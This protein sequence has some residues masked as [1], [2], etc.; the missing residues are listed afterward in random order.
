DLMP[1]S[2]RSDLRA[3]GYLGAAPSEWKEK[4]LGKDLID[5]L[6]LEEWDERVGAVGRG[7]LGLTVACARCHNHKFD[8]ISPQ[9]YYALAGAFT[10]ITPALRPLGEIDAATETH[11]LFARQ[12]VTELNAFANYLTKEKSI[13][14]NAARKKAAECRAEIARLKADMTS[15][16]A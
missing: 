10:S 16:K 14:Q 2:A 13:D 11:Y 9:D 15:V 3:L 1:D 6:L 12:R 8:P 7:F 4:M 5:N